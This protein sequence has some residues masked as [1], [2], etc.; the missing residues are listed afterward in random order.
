MT[1]LTTALELNLREGR[2]ERELQ[3]QPESRR[4]AD[5]L[6]IRRCATG[7]E[8]ALQELSRRYQAP[9]Y[10]FV[11]RQVRS[12]ED[13]EE[14]AIE[15]FVRVWRNA[16]RFRFQATVATWLY[17]IALN[18]VR[19]AYTRSQARPSSVPLDACCEAALFPVESA[20]DASLHRYERETQCRAIQAA[21]ARISESDR[22]VLTLYYLEQWSYE[23]LQEALGISY[24]VLK[25]RLARARTRLMRDLA[26]SPD[27]QYFQS[28]AAST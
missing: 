6:L 23:E 5:E 19:D 10:R 26:A 28:A 16:H 13:A 4:A 8:H 11:R 20:E 2:I 14:I 27:Y 21:L 3:R 17:R 24:T 22:L 7:D 25:T 15:V 1:G 18:L 9:I 12:E